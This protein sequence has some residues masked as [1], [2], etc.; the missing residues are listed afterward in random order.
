[1]QI[2]QVIHVL[3]LN[4]TCGLKIYILLFFSAVYLFFSLISQYNMLIHN[5]NYE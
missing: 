3:M 1:M 2:F 5:L 4:Y